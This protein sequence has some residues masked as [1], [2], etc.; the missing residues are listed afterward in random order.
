MSLI[1]LKICIETTLHLFASNLF[2][3]L[4][5]IQ[6]KPVLCYMTALSQEPPLIASLIMYCCYLLI[7]SVEFIQTTHCYYSCEHPLL[8]TKTLVYT[9]PCALELLLLFSI[10][11][12]HNFPTLLCHNTSSVQIRLVIYV[13]LCKHRCFSLMQHSSNITKLHYSSNLNCNDNCDVNV[14]FPWPA[15]S[16]IEYKWLE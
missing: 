10:L 14:I 6:M 11:P 13:L 8:N 12:S 15:I 9:Y 2:L 4:T 1:S 3:I 7:M 5:N 16:I